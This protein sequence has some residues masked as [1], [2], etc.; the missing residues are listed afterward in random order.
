MKTETNTKTR[1]RN[2]LVFLLGFTALLFVGRWLWFYRGSYTAPD[3]P[4]IDESQIASPPVDYQPFEDEPLAGDGRVVIDLSH[5][6]NLEINDLSPLRDRLEARGVTIETFDGTDASLPAQLHNATAL[7]VIAPTER[8]TA[9][10]REAIMDFVAD[11]G[12]LLLAA[13]PTR[14]VPEE[15]DEEEEFPSLYS[16]FFPT[17][18]VP[19]INSL[20]SAFGVV[21]FDDYLYNLDD[22]AGN[23]RNVK[24]TIFSDEHPLTQDIET[25]VF[26]A[27]HSLRSNG[28]S[29][30]VGDEHTHSPVRSSETG[31]TAATLTADELVL[32]L[33]DVT[34]L[35]APYHTIDDN[36]RFLSHI[37]D[38]LAVDARERDNLE[39]FPYLFEQPVDLVQASGDFLDPQLIAR[40]GE[41][42]EFFDQAGL[43]LT[44]RA[45]AEPDHDAIFV[46]TFDDL[47]LVQDYLTTA[48]VTVTV[49]TNGE[50]RRGAVEEGEEVS[51]DTEETAIEEG[52]GIGTPIPTAVPTPTLEGEKKEIEKKG[53]PV[54]IDIEA[55]GTIGIQGITLFL[56]DHSDDRVA[57][58]VL[59]EDSAMA[60]D[61]VERLVSNDLSSCI[62]VDTVTVCSTGEAQDGLDIEIEIDDESTGENHE[63]LPDESPGGG[64]IFILADDSRSDGA[65]TSATEFEAIIDSGDYAFDIE[66]ADTL[67][68]LENI[69][70]GGVMLTGAQPLPFLGTDHEP[71][72]DLQI[73]DASHPL[74]AGFASDDVLKLLAS[75]SDVPAVVIAG[76]DIDD[77]AQVVFTRGPDSP[78]TGTP[79]LMAAIDEDD[80]V[81]H[82]IIAAFAFYRLPE[83]TQRILALNIAKWLIESD[84]II[85]TK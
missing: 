64:R 8:F 10:E 19:A 85:N 58:I 32:A 56:V 28:L 2:G 4:E 3:I 6:N 20:A 37:A 14:P 76:A 27:A 68:A 50:V 57:V 45:A 55:L 1:I 46:G 23:Y 52:E 22:N 60:V 48:S 31:L 61:A 72:N 66:N 12:R 62:Q 38:W 36:D 82:V 53:H 17:S 69:E 42:L 7:L 26:F 15:E 40:G 77:K 39:D 30:V 5:A 33:G 11:G 70:S 44:L 41:L 54:A 24:F 78:E 81:S 47:E 73:A 13:D 67:S 9:E 34:F 18:A 25:V 21:Y 75:E 35:T 83:E 80:D 74:A 71:I 65:R 43:T 59:A 79:A 63:E 29:L 84:N 51:V 49:D 16:I